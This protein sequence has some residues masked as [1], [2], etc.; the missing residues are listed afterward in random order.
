LT[1]RAKQRHNGIIE[2][3]QLA[4]AEK[5]AAGFFHFEQETFDADD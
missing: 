5:S 2:I 4:R 3:G 1:R